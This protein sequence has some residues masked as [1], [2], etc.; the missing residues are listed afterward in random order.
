MIFIRQQL[1][2]QTILLNE[3]AVPLEWIS[4]ST[5]NDRPLSTELLMMIAKITGL[6][7]AGRR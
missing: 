1:E 5:E 3:L 4:A 2:R 7:R 6:C